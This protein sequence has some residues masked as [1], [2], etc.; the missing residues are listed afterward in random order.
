[1]LIKIIQ[2]VNSKKKQ[3]RIIRKNVCTL[4]DKTGDTMRKTTLLFSDAQSRVCSAFR[5]VPAMRHEFFTL[6]NPAYRLATVLRI[7]HVLC[8]TLEKESPQQRR[9][10]ENERRKDTRKKSKTVIFAMCWR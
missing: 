7:P 6:E 1:M 9:T 5:F 8:S 3:I 4:R 2:K 10:G